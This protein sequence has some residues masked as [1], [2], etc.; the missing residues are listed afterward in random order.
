MVAKS[1]KNYIPDQGDL[2]WL[3]FNPQAGHEQAG[4]RPAL[5]VSPASY[6]GAVGLALICPIT[7][8][9]K[10]Y[11]FEVLLPKKL[12]INGAILSDQI[13]SLDWRVR[14]AKFISKAPAEIVNEVIEKIHA[15]IAHHT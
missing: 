8:K 14:K 13:K 6:N 11:P 12:K 9:I 3:E 4:L 15:I 1:Q 2:V 10:G 5:V 7:S